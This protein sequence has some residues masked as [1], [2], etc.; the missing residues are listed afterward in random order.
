MQ[1]QTKHHYNCIGC[2]KD[3]NTYKEYPDGWIC[4]DC[5]KTA[6]INVKCSV[7]GATVPVKWDTYRMKD[8][9][10]PWRCRACND[11][12]RNDLYEAKPEEEKKAFVASQANRSR[13]Y[14]ANLSDEER[15]KDSLRRKKLWEERKLSG[16]AQRILDAM[17]A[18]HDRWYESL[19]PEERYQRWC[20]MDSGRDVWWSGLT[21]EQKAEHMKHPHEGFRIWFQSLSEEAKRDFMGPLWEGNRKFWG[22]MTK[23]DYQAWRIAF[24]KGYQEYIRRVDPKGRNV[25]PNKNEVEFMDRMKMANIE[26]I[27]QYPSVQVHPDFNKLFPNNPVTGADLVD[28]THMWDFLLQTRD[29]D[30]LVDVDGSMHFKDTYSKIHPYTQKEY[31]ELDYKQF[32]DSQRPYQTDGLPAYAVLCY[33][34]RLTDQTAVVN[35]TTGEKQTFYQWL[36]CMQFRNLTDAEK[37]AAVHSLYGK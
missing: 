22:N 2:G 18:G 14:W 29:G 20:F 37:K 9:S 21:P 15:E 31:R 16:E 12:Y 5:R 30:V 25:E 28:P 24:N 13:A 3:Y 11:K 27:F 1:A 26:F 32:N 4:L 33:D 19:S 36:S 7:C 10:I 35:I 17:H 23:A 34:D 8:P 6:K